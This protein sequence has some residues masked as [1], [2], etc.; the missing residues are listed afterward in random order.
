MS[1]LGEVRRF[2]RGHGKGRPCDVEGCDRPFYARGWCQRHYTRWYKTGRP[3]GLPPGHPRGDRIPNL[4]GVR[5]QL[6]LT[7]RELAEE[8]GVDKHYIYELEKGYKRA[9]KKLQLRLVEVVAALRAE[10]RL[11]ADRLRRAGVA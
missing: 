2:R 11:E 5:K 3:V 7:Q 1:A 4:A 10:K 8:L 9:S 6:G